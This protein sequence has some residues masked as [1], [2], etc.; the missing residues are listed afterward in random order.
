M[1]VLIHTHSPIFLIID[2][3]LLHLHFSSVSAS[4][5]HHTQTDAVWAVTAAQKDVLYADGEG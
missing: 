2:W 4:S 3:I 5:E 1:H